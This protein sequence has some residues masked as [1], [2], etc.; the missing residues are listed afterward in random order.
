MPTEF[1]PLSYWEARHAKF[2]DDYRNV[3]NKTL[4][5]QQNHEMIVVK[6]AMVSHLLGA[7]NV[8]RSARILDAGCGAGALSAI[9]HQAGFEVTGVDGSESAIAN[10]QAR[11]LGSYSVSTLREISYK[12]QFDAVL[13]LDVLYHILDEEEWRGSL[14]ALCD[15]IVE[16]GRLL[17]IESFSPLETDAPHVRW[18]DRATYDAELAQNGMEIVQH[19]VAKYPYE[20]VDKDFLMVARVPTGRPTITTDA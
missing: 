14:H 17:I 13:C 3:G 8:S 11:G 12:N 2:T 16:E 18:R 15:S 6:A 4:S 1:D 7:S 5:S 20:G 19:W 10:A 9:L